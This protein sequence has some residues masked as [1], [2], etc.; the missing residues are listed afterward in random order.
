MPDWVRKKPLSGD[1]HL[2]P[3]NTWEKQGEPNGVLHGKK[4][5]KVYSV[6]HGMTMDLEDVTSDPR[7]PPT[8]TIGFFVF[9]FTIK[10][11]IYTKSNQ[12][13]TAIA[14]PKS[15][16]VQNTLCTEGMRNVGYINTLLPCNTWC[17]AMIQSSIYGV[18][19][20]EAY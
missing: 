6:L 7:A 11:A 18:I 17:R 19:H 5:P 14:N 3:C 2:T 20:G 10:A 12:V 13:P 15:S 1:V 16:T 4:E 8:V 9:S